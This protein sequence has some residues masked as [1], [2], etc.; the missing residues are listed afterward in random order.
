MHAPHGARRA[1][2]RSAPRCPDW[3]FPNADAAGYFRFALAPARPREAAE[4]RARRARPRARRSRTATACAR[5]ST[6]ASTPVRRTSSRRPRRSRR[7]RHPDVAAEPMGFVGH[8][9]R[10]APRRSARAPRSRPTGARSSTAAC[11]KLGW[12][13][14]RRTDDGHGAAP[15]ELGPR[16]P[17]VHRARSRRPRG[18]EEARRSRTSATART[19]RS[20]A[21]AVDANLVGHRARRRGRGGGRPLWDAMRAAFA[22]TEDELARRGLLCVLV[23]ARRAGRSRPVPAISRSTRRSAR[24]R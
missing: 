1:T 19:A 23:S 20:T 13:R 5:R 17:R 2:S 14:R 3:V 8:G 12:T 16:L 18:G 7:T 9:A 11:A 21:D 24:P 10:L 22:K 4:E 15:R 6:A